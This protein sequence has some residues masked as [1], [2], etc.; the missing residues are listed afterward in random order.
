MFSVMELQTF[1]NMATKMF[2]N[3]LKNIFA[4]REANFITAAMFPEVGEQ[5]TLIGN[6]MFPQ[7]C[8]LVCPGLNW[9]GN[10]KRD[11]VLPIPAPAFPP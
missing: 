4:S 3:L 8:F 11:A 1:K 9:L 6:T 5:E 7:Q 10:A 2:L